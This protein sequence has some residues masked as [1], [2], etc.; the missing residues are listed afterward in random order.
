MRKLISIL[1]LSSFYFGF[2]HDIKM[3]MFE[4][5]EG[6]SGLEMTVTVDKEDF[7][8]ALSEEFP[9]KIQEHEIRDLAFEYLESRV[10]I[11]V[12]GACTSF[13]I[14]EIESGD[15]NIHLKG[16]LNLEVDN[17]QK[18][19]ISNTCMI[20]LFEDHDNIV[21]LRLNDR[22][23]SFRMHRNRTSTEAIY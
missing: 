14:H 18:V 9:T 22:N 20:D 19:T 2:G 5:Y 8:S 11:K 13:S 10:S 4:I 1:L 7:Y 16:S 21:K 23:R 15:L 6:K 17:V 12:N 3:A